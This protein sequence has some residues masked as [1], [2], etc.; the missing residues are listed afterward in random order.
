MAK[1]QIKMLV[2]KVCKGSVRYASADD[3]AV[4]TNLYVSKTLADPMPQEILVTIE[5]P[6]QT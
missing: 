4:A 2:E 1:V 6:S 3:T 5:T